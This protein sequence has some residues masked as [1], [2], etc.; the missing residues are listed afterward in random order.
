MSRCSF[1]FDTQKINKQGL[2]VTEKGARGV[3]RPLRRGHSWLNVPSCWQRICFSLVHQFYHWI[4]ICK[5]RNWWHSLTVFAHWK[6]TWEILNGTDLLFVLHSHSRTCPFSI[7][8]KIK[9]KK[10]ACFVAKFV[11]NMVMWWL[12]KTLS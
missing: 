2:N 11:K 8:K 5:R 7:D 10:V 1:F 4:D 6:L 12:K 3:R 9:Y